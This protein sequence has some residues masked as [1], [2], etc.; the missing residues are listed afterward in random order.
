V[1]QVL[2]YYLTHVLEGKEP[3]A[4]ITSLIGVKLKVISAYDPIMPP[5]HANQY[6]SFEVIHMNHGNGRSLTNRIC[7]RHKAV[8]FNSIGSID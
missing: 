4:I 8:G 5:R 1:H 7:K 3:Q 2:T 6:G